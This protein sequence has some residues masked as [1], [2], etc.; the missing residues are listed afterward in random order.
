MDIQ[1]MLIK[2]KIYYIVV[3]FTILYWIFALAARFY[4]SIFMLGGSL[5][6]IHIKLIVVAI[7]IN[8]IN[9]MLSIAMIYFKVWNLKYLLILLG[10][11]ILTAVIGI[12]F[13]SFPIRIM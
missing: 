1:N 9:L 4:P 2:F 5:R 8:I 3:L 6:F 13:I 10:V 11:N 7:I 12:Y